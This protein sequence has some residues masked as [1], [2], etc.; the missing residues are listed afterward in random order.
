M[1]KYLFYLGV[2]AKVQNK[3]IETLQKYLNG[4]SLQSTIENIKP[5]DKYI[6]T[7]GPLKGKR[8]T[9]QEIGKNRLQVVLTD[10]GL[11]VTLNTN[12]N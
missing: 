7:D 6:I 8:S 12:I 9:V 1:Q 4:S 10:L 11:K 5:G 3:E 2:P